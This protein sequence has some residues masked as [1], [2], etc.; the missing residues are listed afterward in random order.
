MHV[1][2]KAMEEERMREEEGRSACS[3]GVGA[4]R[5]AETSDGGL[6]GREKIYSSALLALALSP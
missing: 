1:E 4:P 6:S 2:E 5:G 3:G